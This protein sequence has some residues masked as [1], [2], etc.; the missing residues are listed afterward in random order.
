[1]DGDLGVGRSQLRE[2]GRELTKTKTIVPFAGWGLTKS[3][4]I[5]PAFGWGGCCRGGWVG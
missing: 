5:V 2:G 4:T 1:M 3:K